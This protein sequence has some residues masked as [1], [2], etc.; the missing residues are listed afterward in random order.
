MSKVKKRSR[1]LAE[2]WV[3][4]S[5]GKLERYNRSKLRSSILKAGATRRQA[6]K[7]TTLITNNVRRGNFAKNINGKKEIPSINLSN[8]IISELQKINLNATTNYTN[9]RNL[10]RRTPSTGVQ[11]RI[12]S[13][14][15]EQNISLNKSKRLAYTNRVNTLT[16]EISSINSQTNNV[17]QRIDKFNEQVHSLS[18]RITSIRQGNYRVLTHLEKDQISLSEKWTKLS[19]DLRTITS[20]KSGIVE[21]RTRNLQ[22]AL[23]HNQS[24][25]DYNLGNLQGIDSNISELRLILSEIQGY[26]TSS[27]TPLEKN[28][29]KIDLDL[30]KAERTVTLINQASFP[31]IEGET[32][33]ISTKAKDLI[34]NSNGIITLTNLNFIYEHEKEIVLKKRFFIVTEKKIVREVVVHKPIGMVTQITKGRVGLLKGSGLFIEFAPESGIPEMKLDTKGNEAEWITQSYNYIVSGQADQELSGITKQTESDKDTPQLLI[35]QICGAPYNE[36]IYRGQ[37]SVNCKYCKTVITLQ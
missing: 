28:Y 19:P 17:T 15:N 30:R 8:R 14:T 35:C 6:Q 25:L 36:K 11:F 10:K 24:R 29:Q 34:N 5:N 1:L 18:S 27:L 9:Y 33:I 37:I 3:R 32:P 4:K 12:P 21:S 22:Q 16:S 31:W 2:S 7:I 26:V 13:Q 20:Q 23:T